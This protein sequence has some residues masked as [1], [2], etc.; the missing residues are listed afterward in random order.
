MKPSSKFFLC[1]LVTFCVTFGVLS[2]EHAVARR[3]AAPMPRPKAPAAGAPAPLDGTPPT[4]QYRGELPPVPSLHGVDVQQRK[5][6]S[7][8]N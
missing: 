7:V 5:S 4:L 6:G 2:L 8:L 1:A 3:G